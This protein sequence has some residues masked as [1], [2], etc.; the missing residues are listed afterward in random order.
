MQG[1]EVGIRRE[2]I[3]VRVP[4]YLGEFVEDVVPVGGIGGDF[5][6]VVDGVLPVFSNVGLEVLEAEV[7]IDVVW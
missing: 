3:G 4:C 7:A 1:P 6:G 2:R 5:V